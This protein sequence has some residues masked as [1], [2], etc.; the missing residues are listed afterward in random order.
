MSS[1]VE[2]ARLHQVTT[3][4]SDRLTRCVLA[5][6]DP[7]LSP[8]SSVKNDYGESDSGLDGV[9]GLAGGV[10]VPRAGSWVWVDSPPSVSGVSV[11]AGDSFL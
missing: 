2:F 11:V 3:K 9:G 6:R 4:L 7:S 10:S 1:L 8:I 5:Q